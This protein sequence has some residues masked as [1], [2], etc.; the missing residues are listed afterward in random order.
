M[1]FLISECITAHLACD[2][3][4]SNNVDDSVNGLLFCRG[5]DNP[6]Y[7][8]NSLRL[9]QEEKIYKVS[10]LNKSQLQHSPSI[11]HIYYLPWLS[12][13]WLT[14]C[15]ILRNAEVHDR[16]QE[17]QMETWC[18]GSI[19]SLVLKWPHHS[20]SKKIMRAA[21]LPLYPTCSALRRA[22]FF[23]LD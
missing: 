15:S 11:S 6:L 7:A 14:S 4:L 12:F 5:A 13:S 19:N 22:S 9:M 1:S 20:L 3:G 8:T 2:Y 16:A 21:E 18:K 10:L 17:M 23:K